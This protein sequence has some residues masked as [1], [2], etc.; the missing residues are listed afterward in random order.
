MPKTPLLF[1]LALCFWLAA[2]LIVAQDDEAFDYAGTRECRD[3]HRAISNVHS[4]SPHALTLIEIEEDMDEDENPIVADFALDDEVR[5]VVFP[6]EDDARIFD[7]E[8]V[9]YTLG[10]GRHVQAFVTGNEDDGYFVPPIQWNVSDATWDVLAAGT[11]EEFIPFGEQCAG[12]HTVGLDVED[13]YE[14][15]EEGVMC[16]ACH[17]PGLLHVELV[18]DAGRDIDEE[19]RAQIYDSIGLA[20]DGAACGQCH[21]RGLATD[22]I[23]PYPVDYFPNLTQLSD[24]FEPLSE[25]DEAFHA[26]GHAA[27]P[28]M[29]YNE[30]LISGH[31]ESLVNAQASENFGAECLSCHSVTQQL[32]DLRLSNEDIDP[33]T[34]DPLALV[35]THAL[36]V[37]CASCHDAHY[38]APDDADEAMEGQRLRADVDMLCV[39]CHSDN[40]LSD[41]VHYPVQQ[42]YEGTT[43]VEAVEAIPG[44][45]FGA[46]DGPTCATCHMAT[47]PTYSGERNS[48]TFA[49]V[50]PGEALDIENLQDSCSGC[51]EDVTAPNLQLLI[52]DIQADTRNR[53]EIAREA[54]NDDTP[55]WVRVALDAIEGDGSA[56]MHNYA[57][58]DE[59]LDAIEAALNLTEANS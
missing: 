39:S 23:H 35:E 44:A 28:N 51:H 52:D 27:L 38:I 37:T 24:A 30:T 32:V 3:C 4:D 16:E 11:S 17:G 19:E 5:S 55:D 12:C 29:Q 14:W 22:G 43:L 58:T 20:L 25:D 40:D 1:L 42:L 41:G 8:D 10:A 6:G 54:L 46:E 36:G 9:A 7:L 53:I 31:P 56:G 47:I 48:H 45:H 49:I 50:A 34:V 26:S 2:A 15:E 59:L 57:Y 33:E 18:D 21:V 13:N